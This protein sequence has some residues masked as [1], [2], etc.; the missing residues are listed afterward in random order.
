MNLKITTNEGGFP[1]TLE[2]EIYAILWQRMLFESQ[3]EI[4]FMAGEAGISSGMS[5]GADF[6]KFNFWSYNDCVETYLEEIF[7]LVYNFE[8]DEIFFD[9][10]KSSKLR[11]YKNLLQEEPYK[12]FGRQWSRVLKGGHS[13]HEIIEVLESVTYEH[14]VAFKDTFMRNLK[15]EGLVCGHL[16]ISRAKNLC[17]TINNSIKHIPLGPDDLVVFR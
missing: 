8:T 14:L 1:F 10:L 13:I 4:D 15:F 6:I 17:E 16:D 11:Y 7:Q 2:S 5:I 12:R 3:R 9:N